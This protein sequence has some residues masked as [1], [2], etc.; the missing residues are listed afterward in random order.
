[1][2]AHSDLQLSEQPSG[3]GV[4]LRFLDLQVTLWRLNNLLIGRATGR[5]M[6]REPRFCVRDNRLYVFPHGVDR[7]GRKLVCRAKFSSKLGSTP[8]Y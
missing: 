3:I 2:L 1:M 4:E 5:I 7:Q 6:P 8:N